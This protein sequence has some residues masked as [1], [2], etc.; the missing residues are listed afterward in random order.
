[1]SV[2]NELVESMAEMI[3]V[4]L[5]E[6]GGKEYSKTLA[7]TIQVIPF[8]TEIFNNIT[9]DIDKTSVQTAS[10]R[11]LQSILQ[12]I[13]M[14]S[15]QQPEFK[16]IIDFLTKF[17]NFASILG[18]ERLFASIY[19]TAVQFCQS[20][21][22]NLNL[23]TP[24]LT[25]LL[26]IPALANN[27]IENDGL[28]F[29]IFQKMM[30]K[31]TLL[32]ETALKIIFANIH[33]YNLALDVSSASKIFQIVSQSFD[34]LLL[35]ES[36]QFSQLILYLIQLDPKKLYP[37]AIESGL[38][39]QMIH[40]IVKL[41]DVSDSVAT[42]LTDYIN[43]NPDPSQLP[44]A[45]GFLVDALTN[46][47]LINPDTYNTLLTSL[48]QYIQ[49]RKP[50]EDIL[51]SHL[52]S[53]IAFSMNLSNTKAVEKYIGMLVY[54]RY[55]LNYNILPIVP[56]ILRFCNL[57]T[58]LN[59]DLTDLFHLLLQMD[60]E[61]Q[62]FALSFFAPFVTTLNYSDSKELFNKYPQLVLFLQRFYESLPNQQEKNKILKIFISIF[63]DLDNK[64]E[65]KYCLAQLLQG[66]SVYPQIIDY[67][68]NYIEI[69]KDSSC[70]VEVLMISSKSSSL[71]AEYLRLNTIG[72][73]IQLYQMKL[74][75]IKTLVNYVSI[76]SQGRFIRDYNRM[77]SDYIDRLDNFNLSPEEFLRFSFGKMLTDEISKPKVCFPTLI[78][79]AER[80]DITD[81]YDL[82]LIELY[83]EY[84]NPLES[85]YLPRISGTYV[86]PKLSKKIADNS[87][88][89]KACS[90]HE[91]NKFPLFQFPGEEAKF[92][93][94]HDDN[95]SILTFWFKLIESKISEFV[96]FQGVKL[97]LSK[98]GLMLDNNLIS[99]IDSQNWYFI[100]LKSD[101]NNLNIYVNGKLEGNTKVVAKGNTTIGG[102]S[103]N[104][105]TTIIRMYDQKSDEMD[106]VMKNGYDCLKKLKS[107]LHIS[108][109][110]FLDIDSNYSL[111]KCVTGSPQIIPNYPLPKYIR[112]VLGGFH[113]I[114]QKFFEKE[115]DEKDGL[116]YLE[117][118][119]N[120]QRRGETDF[121]NLKFAERMSVIASFFEFSSD[122]VKS[123]IDLFTN[124]IVDWISFESF[125]L[126]IDR[127]MT[128]SYKSIIFDTLLDLSSKEKFPNYSLNVLLWLLLIGTE[129][130]REITQIVSKLKAVHKIST[131][132]LFASCYKCQCFPLL[133]PNLMFNILE[134][135]VSCSHL[136]YNLPHDVV[137]KVVYNIQ[138]D[139]NM[140][141][142]LKNIL[143]SL[144]QQIM[145]E[146][147]WSAIIHIVT[148]GSCS[149]YNNINLQNF[150][151]NLIFP[152]LS[153]IGS[154]VYGSS[155][156]KQDNKWAKIGTTI[157]DEFSNTVIPKQKKFG[158]E[159][160]MWSSILMCLG[161]S[162]YND[163]SIAPDP[164]RC[165]VIFGFKP[166]PSQKMRRVS[167][168]GP[169]I[170]GRRR[171][172]TVK[173]L[174]QDSKIQFM[175]ASSPR[176]P[177]IADDDSFINKKVSGNV[178]ESDN[179][180][181]VSDVSIEDQVNSGSQ[182]RINF[183]SPPSPPLSVPSSTYST[184]SSSSRKLTKTTVPSFNGLNL[185]IPQLPGVSNKVGSLP[186]KTPV[187]NSNLSFPASV[188]NSASSFIISG[189]P[190]EVKFNSMIEKELEVTI[191]KSI[192][193]KI[194][195]NPGANVVMVIPKQ[196]DEFF[197]PLF[198][199]IDDYLHYCTELFKDAEIDNENQTVNENVMESVA[200]FIKNIVVTSNNAQTILIPPCSSCPKSYTS[201]LLSKIINLLL[202]KTEQ[203]DRTIFSHVCNLILD[204]WLN[205][206][207]EEVLNLSIRKCFEDKSLINTNFLL[208][209]A[210]LPRIT[211]TLGDLINENCEWIFN[212]D[213]IKEYPYVSACIWQTCKMVHNMDKIVEFLNKSNDKWQKV[214]NDQSD[215]PLQSAKAI[216]SVNEGCQHRSEQMNERLQKSKASTHEKID[217]IR[218]TG[219]EFISNIS[220]MTAMANTVTDLL[221]RM[222]LESFEC[223]Y[224]MTLRKKELISWSISKFKPH[225]SDRKCL[226]FLGD[227]F[228]PSRRFDP[229]PLEYEMPPYPG[230]SIPDLY[231]T[232]YKENIFEETSLYHFTC[233]IY[234][235]VSEIVDEKHKMFCWNFEINTN[236]RLWI[237]ENLL[238]EGNEFKN[239]F[240]CHIL[241]GIDPLEGVILITQNEFIFLEGFRYNKEIGFEVI[242][243]TES[244][245]L[246][247]RYYGHIILNN[248]FGKSFTFFGHISFRLCLNELIDIR[249]H[250]WLQ[251]KSSAVLTFIR[252]QQFVV[253]T[254]VTNNV[255]F[256]QILDQIIEQT[257]QSLP[258][259]VSSFM[260]PINTS[261]LLRNTSLKDITNK[262]VNGDISTFT[263]ICIVN[264]LSGRTIVDHT[265]YYVFP[266]VLSDYDNEDVRESSLRDLRLPMGQLPSDRK[267]GYDNTYEDSDH[268]F[269]YGSHYMH[270]GVVLFFNFRADP[271]CLLGIHLNRGWDHPNRIFTSVSDSWRS[272]SFSTPADVKELTPQL[273]NSPEILKSTSFRFVSTERDASFV[274][275]PKWS[276]SEYDFS[277]K[278]MFSLE[279]EKVGKGIGNW[280]DLIFGEKS[281]GELAIE[282]KNLFHPLTYADRVQ[283]DDP[284]ETE[285]NEMCILNFGQCPEQIFTKT[286]PNQKSS[287]T[288]NLMTN[289]DLFIQ[290]INPQSDKASYCLVYENNLS[291]FDEKQ[292]ILPEMKSPIN[293]NSL[294]HH[295]YSKYCYSNDGI[296]LCTSIKEGLVIIYRIFYK[297]EQATNAAL[298]D[299]FYI[300]GKITS[301]CISSVHY[302]LCIS[303][304]NKVDV[305]DIG[306]R[307][308]LHNI[309]TDS[310][311]NKIIIDDNSGIMFFVHHHSV[312]S[313]SIS[314]DKL[315]TFA[316]ENNTRI[317]CFKS[318]NLPTSFV[319]RFVVL[320]SEDNSLKF[321]RTCDMS[322]ISSINLPV[323]AE[324]VF[325]QDKCS[326]LVFVSSDKRWFSV[327]S[328]DLSVEYPLKK[329]YCVNCCVC[330]SDLNKSIDTCDKCGRF[331]C[332]KCKQLCKH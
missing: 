59:V 261:R 11:Y 190:G 54:L 269:Y 46:E 231:K 99:K 164:T 139:D 109:N 111:P 174:F 206:H 13:D 195:L 27:F 108:P 202:T 8:F 170:G 173:N 1:M 315:Y 147:T 165:E 115:I 270:F 34:S 39:V 198:S 68:M 107:L 93:I 278:M 309:E 225:K 332:S 233:R 98:K 50:S 118:L 42:I 199:D 86:C 137:M 92:S 136:L 323:C 279:Q 7:I 41:Q 239:I 112:N 101:D 132:S 58:A 91:E 316:N 263:Y 160:T 244:E 241:W 245:N 204:G 65:A 312:D 94:K 273:Y 277:Q 153:L 156:S 97:T 294:I 283:S 267:K 201:M 87:L 64:T 175:P 5:N 148:H 314:S 203:L 250:N 121:D 114:L 80:Y 20:D 293:I 17:M 70:F 191:K 105:I 296:Y 172:S 232:L 180:T 289:R 286:H 43:M 144:N 181:D 242:E 259:F 26:S 60:T 295:N 150:D 258:P 308:I 52:I 246:S 76:L 197:S 240:N 88:L 90:S 163:D 45:I 330:G 266:W 275:L 302:I 119:I 154:L 238:N 281:R 74:L 179:V 317:T 40:T 300:D 49:D 81:L 320:C 30:K 287:Y 73:V 169:R 56:G 288:W 217:K 235:P 29:A 138:F 113:Y 123:L 327:E 216:Q 33:K 247:M 159:F 151:I 166:R 188:E 38:F 213:I 223:S 32:S 187:V 10:Q 9:K 161:Y 2:K 228:L 162:L 285:A 66:A 106:N 47:N 257:D 15:Q 37:L 227:T 134:N 75:D 28:M 51:K 265:Q 95:I 305:Y 307:T 82:L 53:P 63:A 77:I 21:S 79:R 219:N 84:E 133:D 48:D 152:F 313:Y 125:F 149:D 12:N 178:S 25:Q 321:I 67:L 129:Q 146:D 85:P 22:D 224:C 306:T 57:T 284:L 243:Q 251:K 253:I 171:S 96:T 36:K 212:S 184:Y 135:T 189:L 328:L 100:Y 158:Q 211:A 299:K 124:P 116:N 142:I 127:L 4:M 276:S 131:T 14:F 220:Q 248:Y 168:A 126:D 89:F 274:V 282:S 44:P 264:I 272:A 254:D 157:L 290:Q 256:I 230:G 207:T 35:D 141:N 205:E 3:V 318:S 145:F 260:T 291:F 23:L 24:S 6:C 194:E 31:K 143:I 16:T 72:T 208:C 221:R 215:N 229:S 262:W 128:S 192:P 222:Y 218:I 61:F 234:P 71:L 304:E 329:T 326:R 255:K 303:Y 78:Q 196:T 130:S 193:S 140:S 301:L 311:I 271:F 331:L 104:F 185:P 237:L 322:L 55:T 183:S 176:I 209:L 102:K 155:I 268:S 122:I 226:T 200:L 236:L 319:D 325:I 83:G 110:E 252:G 177:K 210:F 182:G 292:F 69:Q 297:K 120:Y 310:L 167:D 298:I 186:K 249:I 62:P 103:T 280:F 19:V 18:V 214:F 324:N 117:G